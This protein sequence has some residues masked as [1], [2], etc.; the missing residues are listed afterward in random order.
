MGPL[1]QLANA[2]GLAPGASLELGS[3]ATG[4]LGLGCS[5]LSP[6]HSTSLGQ[7]VSSLQGMS[8]RA[9]SAPSHWGFLPGLLTTT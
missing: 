3:Y 5:G 1:F 7:V 8:S 4:P 2:L 6:H 9:D